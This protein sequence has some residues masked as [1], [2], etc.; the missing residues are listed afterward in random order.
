M[1]LSLAR[2]N[3]SIYVYVLE[4]KRKSIVFRFRR[5][6][7]RSLCPLIP[8]CP[9]C[10]GVLVRRHP[11]AAAS[12]LPSGFPDTSHAPPR[13]RRHSQPS[14]RDLR[15]NEQRARHRCRAPRACHWLSPLAIFQPLFGKAALLPLRPLRAA[16][17]PRTPQRPCRTPWWRTGWSAPRR[18]RSPVPSP[19]RPPT[20]W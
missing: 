5:V 8:G 11:R 10:P 19:S 16:K 1:F 4:I 7:K 12:R 17:S 18:T 14:A 6:G 3:V 15:P 2:F 9:G 20:G 13:W